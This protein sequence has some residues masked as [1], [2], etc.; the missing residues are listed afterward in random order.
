MIQIHFTTQ[1]HNKYFM[2]FTD[3]LFSDVNNE[4]KYRLTNKTLD[5]R[6]CITNS[7]VFIKIPSIN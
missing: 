2:K 1:I 5:Q 4:L 6:K 7:V 3:Y